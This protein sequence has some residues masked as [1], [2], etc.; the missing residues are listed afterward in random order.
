[1]WIKEFSNLLYP[2]CLCP[3]C[4]VRSKS[5]ICLVVRLFIVLGLTYRPLK[6]G[7]P[8]YALATYD[9]RIKELLNQI[10][11]Q[12]DYQLAVTLVS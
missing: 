2:L 12:N 11:Y 5:R 1:M 9:G 3:I 7:F 8:A 6:T 10:E 4:Q